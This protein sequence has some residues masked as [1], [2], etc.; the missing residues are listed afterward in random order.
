[1]ELVHIKMFVCFI[2]QNLQNVKN[3]KGTN[4]YAI[5]DTCI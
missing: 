1:M 3:V 5:N 2:G 4:Y